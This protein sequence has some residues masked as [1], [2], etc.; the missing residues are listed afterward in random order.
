MP[1]YVNT[2]EISDDEVFAEMQHHPS[3]TVDDAMHKAATALAIHEML[4]QEA[5]RLKIFAPD[6][7]APGETRNEYLINSLLEQEVKIPSPDEETCLRYYE[8]NRAV[9]CDAE[10]NPVPFIYVKDRIAA[11]LEDASWQIAIKQYLQILI[12]KTKFSGI[13]L[14]GAE[15]PLVQ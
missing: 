11:Y 15:T 7:N 14:A 8:Q 2:A 13:H 4:L 9:F 6:T 5:A 1:F 12:G 3:V 10:G